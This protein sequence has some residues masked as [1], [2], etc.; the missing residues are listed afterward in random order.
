MPFLAF[1]ILPFGLFLPGFLIARRLQHTLP[2]LSA[3]FLSE[4]VLFH[5]IFWIGILHIPI[6]LWTVLPCIA[7]VSAAVLW[8]RRSS[9]VPE[10]PKKQPD[11]K[12]ALQETKAA[13]KP[14]FPARIRSVAASFAS[15]GG[16][17]TARS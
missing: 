9:P 11:S 13:G 2:W 4:L 10:Q 3:F 7:A 1:L 12:L 17:T 6:T 14:S 8:L 15:G 5:C 16:A